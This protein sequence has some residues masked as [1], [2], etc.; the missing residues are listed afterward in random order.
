MGFLRSSVER[1]QCRWTSVLGHLPNVV[2][3]IGAKGVVTHLQ[4]E[5]RTRVSNDGDVCCGLD[6][7]L[8]FGTAYARFC[9]G[10]AGVDGLSV[11]GHTAERVHAIRHFAKLPYEGV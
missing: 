2:L 1:G 11:K 9:G 5:L 6:L 3:Q 4:G 10:G 8:H 7:D